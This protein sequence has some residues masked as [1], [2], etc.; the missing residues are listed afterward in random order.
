MVH[1]IENRLMLRPGEA[2]DALGV[3]RAKIYELIATGALPSVRVGASIR[4]PLDALK[5][6]IDEQLKTKV[7]QAAHAEAGGR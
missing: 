7:G 3:S 1:G 5:L 4:L 6:W 2:A